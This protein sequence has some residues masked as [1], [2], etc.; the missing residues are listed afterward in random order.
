LLEH[1]DRLRWI[2]ALRESD[3]IF[4]ALVTHQQIDHDVLPVF[5]APENPLRVNSLE[6]AREVGPDLS[7]ELVER[8]APVLMIKS[9]IKLRRHSLH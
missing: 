3:P 1:F 5:A 2:H 4:V 9:P 8:L 6:R 7:D